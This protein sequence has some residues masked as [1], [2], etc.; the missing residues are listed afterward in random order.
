MCQSKTF[1]RD[2][3]WFKTELEKKEQITKLKNIKL[4]ILDVDGTLTDGFMDY[5]EDKE[6]SRRFSIED[7]YAMVLGQKAGLKLVLLSGKNHNSIQ[8]RAEKLKIPSEFVINGH[9][10]KSFY[11]KEIQKKYSIYDSETLIFGDDSLDARA[12]REIPD[13]FFVT[14]A[15]APFYYQ[16]FADLVIPKTGGNH[17]LR[18]LLDLILFVQEKHFDQDLIAAVLQ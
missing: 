16:A 5:T 18:L 4:L 17:A 8:L 14:P 9:E 12:K 11:I 2:L 3:N 15:N 1:I 6:F 7:G 10:N 13:I